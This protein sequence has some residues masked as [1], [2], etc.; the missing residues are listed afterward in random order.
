MT[1]GVD[2]GVGPHQV[3]LAAAL[4]IVR[5]HGQVRGPRCLPIAV[6]SGATE[7]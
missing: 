1:H 7:G 4:D 2:T 6:H 5:T 3:G